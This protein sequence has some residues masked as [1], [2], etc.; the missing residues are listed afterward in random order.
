V[1]SSLVKLSSLAIVGGGGGGGGFE[2]NRHLSTS[3]RDMKERSQER[4]KSVRS[5]AENVPV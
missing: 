5:S 4:C 1:V 2:C 3:R